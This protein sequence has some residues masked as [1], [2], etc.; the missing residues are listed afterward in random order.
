MATINRITKLTDKKYVN[1]YQADGVNS[2]GYESHYLIASRSE[3]VEG[4]KMNCGLTRPDAVAVYAV[5]DGK[6]VLVKQYRY[7][8]NAWIYELPA[9]LVENGEDYHDTAVREMKEETG[10]DLEV[11]KVDPMIEKASF[12]S[13][14]MSDESTATVYG[15]A[16]GVVSDRFEEASEEI[17]VV[18][19]D[20][21]ECMRILREENVAMFCQY[22]LMHFISDDEPFGFLRTFQNGGSH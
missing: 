18:L 3:T 6:V 9:G 1:L 5:C 12:T 2:K 16:A 14:G 4:L 11:I 15:Y 10:L 22:Q 20:K 13:V 7:P 21:E 8:I 17:E 19:A